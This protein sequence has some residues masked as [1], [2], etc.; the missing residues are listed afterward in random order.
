MSVL[1]LQWWERYTLLGALPVVILALTVRLTVPGQGPVS[2]VMVAYTAMI[3]AIML[4]RAARAGWARQGAVH[5]LM[6]LT[7]GFAGVAGI[8][9]F[10][11]ALP[12]WIAPLGVF[13]VLSPYVAWLIAATWRA[14]RGGDPPGSP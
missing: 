8:A 14:Q 13:G 6:P 12:W 5:W 4:L 10:F 1:P 9:A 11:G 7:A 3:S 2:S